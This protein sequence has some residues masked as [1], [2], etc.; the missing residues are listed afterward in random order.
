ME[1][2]IKNQSQEVEIDIDSLEKKTGKIL[3]GLDC[4][5]SELSVL[6]VDDKE[7]QGLNREYRGI[8]RPTDVLSFSM[9]EGESLEFNSWLL[10]DI[11]VSLETASRQADE[12]GHSLE[13]EVLI[14]M[15][16]GI[17]H[18]LG[19]RHEDSDEYARIMKDK[20]KQILKGIL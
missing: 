13:D 12:K 16:H 19:Y 5:D 3:E 9:Q 7:I 11:V 4:R 2:I 10:G 1:I 15:V 6:L 18:L 14:L 20:E 8:D 17:L